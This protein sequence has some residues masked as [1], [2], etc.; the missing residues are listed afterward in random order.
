LTVERISVSGTPNVS[1]AFRIAAI[2]AN[3]LIPAST[4]KRR[5]IELADWSACWGE[6]ASSRGTSR[7]GGPTIKIVLDI[8]RLVEQGKLTGQ[9]AERL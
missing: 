2:H 9:E 8:T 1:H 3:E 5:S 4:Q 6:G 7:E